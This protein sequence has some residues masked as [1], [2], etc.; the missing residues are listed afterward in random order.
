MNH[1]CVFDFETDEKHAELANPV[2]VACAML[3]PF[4]LEF[5]KGSEFCSAIRPYGIDDVDYLT[6]DRL[7]TIKWH[8]GLKG[9]TQAELLDEWRSNPTEEV[10]WKQFIGHVNIYNKSNSRYHA[11]I[12]AGMNINLFDLVIADRLNVRYKQ[13]TFF[14]YE[15]VDLR[16]LAFTWLRWDKNLRKRTLDSLREY[17]GIEQDEAHNAMPDVID[18]GNLI[19]K[20]LLLQKGLFPR[21]KF[22]GSLAPIAVVNDLVARQAAEEQFAATESEPPEPPVPPQIV[23]I[24]EGST[25]P[26]N[27]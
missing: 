8:C 11:P 27:R 18:S 17:F 7:D 2:E 16:D 9:C 3:D 20:F 25:Q 23:K 24:M 6:K 21:V 22:K 1:F 26:V 15:S 10:V 12:A 19:S 13:A 4:S 14:N 5:V